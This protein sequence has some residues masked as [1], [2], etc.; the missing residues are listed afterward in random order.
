[1]NNVR[2]NNQI[3]LTYPDGFKEMGAEELTRYFSSPN[4]RWG[5]YNAD[6]HI[7]LSVSWNK[8][9][10]FGS[11]SDADSVLTG[12]EAR[13]CRSLLNYQRLNRYKL[14]IGSQKACGVRFEYRVNDARLVQ[15]GDLVV[16]KYKKLF[17]SVYYVTRKTNAGSARLALQETLKSIT[18]N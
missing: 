3:D 16:F 18:L 4:N 2:I 17:Y 14:K 10:F 5:V 6:E 15:I 9:G 13:M 8:P 12:A 1:M 11:F 7:I